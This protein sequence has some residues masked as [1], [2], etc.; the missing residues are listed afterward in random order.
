[1]VAMLNAL[2]REAHHIRSE[3]TSH[4]IS[5]ATATSAA[6][7]NRIEQEIVY[8]TRREGPSESAL[9]I[10]TGKAFTKPRKVCGNPNCKC[11]GHT[12]SECF[13][14]GGAMEGRRE[15]V[16]ATKAKAREERN[17]S[18]PKPNSNPA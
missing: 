9:A 11:T 2:E 7:S 17:K 8:K 18:N 14:R 1:M 10:R 5:N 15:E 6:L 12:T 3:M 16:L 4:Y 13:Q